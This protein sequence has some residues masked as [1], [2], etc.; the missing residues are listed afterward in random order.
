MKDLIYGHAKAILHL[1]FAVNLL[2]SR[3]YGIRIKTAVIILILAVPVISLGDSVMLWMACWFNSWSC[4]TILLFA[5]DLLR[6]WY[7]E[8]RI[9]TA[10]IIQ[11]F[12]VPI[13]SLGDSVMLWI[14]WYSL[15]VR[16]IKGLIHDHATPY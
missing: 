12:T 8:I 1:V 15:K 5:A 13:I 11:I 10:M 4:Q 6:T 9:K 7:Y 2:S 16:T 14:A 3:Y